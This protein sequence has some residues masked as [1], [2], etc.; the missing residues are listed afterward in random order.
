MNK[1]FFLLLIYAAIIQLELERQ[2]RAS[3]QN[4]NSAGSKDFFIII[5][6]SYF[7]TDYKKTFDNK[8]MSKFDRQESYR[9]KSPMERMGKD[10]V[11]SEKHV[12]S[13]MQKMNELKKDNDAGPNQDQK[14]KTSST[15][16]EVRESTN[17][18]KPR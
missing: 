4:A 9:N 14:H 8:Y 5:N 3:M 15:E 16:I 10:Y 17:T 2:S 13:T 18:I 12:Q 11:N 1:S 7:V 6:L